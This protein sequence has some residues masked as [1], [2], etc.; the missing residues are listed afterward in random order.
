[1]IRIAVSL[2]VTGIFL[3]FA[4]RGQDF[5]QLRDAILQQPLHWLMIMFVLN[6]V[7][8]ILRALRWKILLEPV[9]SGISVHSTFASLM[10]GFMI[11]GFIPRAGEIGRSYVLG[12]KEHIP[13]S[14]VLSTVILERILDFV[15]FA[16]VLCVVVI[17]NSEALILWFPSFA[18]KE[19]LMDGAAVAL[20]ALFVLLFVKSAVVFS[21]IRHLV[22]FFPAASRQKI[23]RII[24]SFMDGFKASTTKKNYGMIALLTCSIWSMYVIILYLPMS[25]FNMEHLTLIAGATLQV[26]SGLAAAMPTPNGIGSYHTFLA[27][28][29]TKGYGAAKADAFAYV[30]YTHAIYYFSILIVGTVY[31]LRENIRL[32]ELV[33]ADKQE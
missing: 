3:W 16:S 1:M 23:D 30:V 25:L 5:G 24:E 21:L 20:L 7:S 17:F 15:S 18:G 32:A 9:K 28:T 6:I 10:V 22:R 26:L 31:L 29:L 19:L 4:F 11:N 13:A 14:S 12:R 2:T 8:H 27:F 33:E